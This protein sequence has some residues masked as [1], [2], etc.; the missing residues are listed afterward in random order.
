MAE[1]TKLILP[2]LFG[3]IIG[4]AL[5]WVITR[6]L[7]LNREHRKLQ[8]EAYYDFLKGVA[9]SAMQQNEEKLIEHY[10]LVANAKSRIALYGSEQAVKALAN[11]CHNTDQC[12]GNPDTQKEYA[13]LCLY[14]RKDSLGEKQ[15]ASVEDFIKIFFS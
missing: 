11:F 7:E 14:M 9:G 13:N 6:K 5:Q 3:I 15:L 1:L 2:S 8:S 4:A 10:M 12:L